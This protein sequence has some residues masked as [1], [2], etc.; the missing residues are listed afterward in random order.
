[1]TTIKVP[2]LAALAGGKDS[3][4]YSNEADPHESDFQTTFFG[5]NYKKLVSIKRKYD[6]NGMFIVPAGVESE[7]FDSRG[8]CRL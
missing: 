3:G 6:R 2:I 1:M 5:T 4:A 8:I 7:Y